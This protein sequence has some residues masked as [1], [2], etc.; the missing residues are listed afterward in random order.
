MYK[1]L[2]VPIDGTPLASLTVDQAIDFA[3]EGQARIT[4]F[5]AQEDFAGTGDG[6]LLHAKD[7]SAFAEAA[8]GNSRAWLARAAAAATAAQVK[9]QTLAVISDRPHEAILEAARNAGCDLVFMASHGRGGL[10]GKLAGSVTQ[11]VIQ[12]ATLPVLVARVESNSALSDE[13]RALATIRDEHRSLAAVIHAMRQALEDSVRTGNAPDFTL[14]RAALFYLEAFPERLHHPKEEQYLFRNLRQRTNQY[15]DVLA[16][17]EQ[18]HRE[19]TVALQAMRDV[20]AWYEEDGERGQVLFTQAL[21]RFAKSQW[22][23]MATEEKLVLPMASLHLQPE[24]WSEI[25]RAFDDNADPCLG[26]DAEES[27]SQ[28]FTRLMNLAAT[29]SASR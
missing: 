21:E 8:A 22:R 2:L 10:R 17:L 26:P 6:V 16:G 18:Q 24:D 7:P 28:V 14:L 25:A 19:S 23:H 9:H 20:L 27:F 4:F 13:Q 15:D 3:R 1:H 5:H 11:R 12:L 29:P